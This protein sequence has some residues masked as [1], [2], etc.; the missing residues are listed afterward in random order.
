MK[1]FVP[2]V[3]TVAL[4]L[5]VSGCSADSDTASTPVTVTETTV[6][7]TTVKSQAEKSEDLQQ[8]LRRTNSMYDVTEENLRTECIM[9]IHAELPDAGDYDFPEPIDFGTIDPAKA[10]HTAGGDF[11]YQDASDTWVEGA[12]F[13]NV[14]SEGG[15]IT[16]AT[17]VAV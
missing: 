11:L 14:Y 7:T 8:Q 16:R 4:T 9:A 10:V 13:C 6:S 15:T 3:F 12:Y 17:A 5:A 2:S 1:K